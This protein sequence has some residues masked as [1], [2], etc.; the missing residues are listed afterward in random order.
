M[1]RAWEKKVWVGAQ[2]ERITRQP[3]IFFIHR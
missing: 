2:L 1:T 3:I